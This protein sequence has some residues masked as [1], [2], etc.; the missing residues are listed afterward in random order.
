MSGRKGKYLI[1]IFLL[2][3][4]IVNCEE[5][6]ESYISVNIND[7]L[8]YDFSRVYTNEDSSKL[9]INIEDMLEIIEI[10]TIKID[11]ENKVIKGYVDKQLTESGEEISIKWKLGS[12]ALI[13]EEMLYVEQESIKR[14]F[15][16]KDSRWDE[17]EQTYFLNFDFLTPIE[18]KMRSE[19]WRERNLYT[20][21]NQEIEGGLEV[22]R[23]LFTPGILTFTFDWDDFSESDQT[24]FLEYNSIF[25]RGELNVS[26]EVYE[27]QSLDF[28]RLDYDNIIEDKVISIGDTTIFNAPSIFRGNSNLR[29][30]SINRKNVNYTTNNING[31]EVIEGFAPVR[32]SVELYQNGF[33]I[34]FQSV[35]DNGFFRF[36]DIRSKSLSDSYSVKIYDQ[37]GFF[38]E[39]RSYSSLLN[40]DFMKKGEFDYQGAIGEDDESDKVAGALDLYYGIFSRLTYNPG[41]YYT[42][43]TGYEYSDDDN[44]NENSGKEVMKNS[45]LYRSKKRK[46]P[47]YVKTDLYTDIDSMSNRYEMEYTQKFFFGSQ[48]E[49]YYTKNEAIPEELSGYSDRYK[50]RLSWSWKRWYTSVTYERESAT[51]EE[52]EEN[53][54]GEI[55]YRINN[56]LQVSL[57]EDYDKTN[58]LHL[59][60]LSADYNMNDSINWRASVGKYWGD[61]DGSEYLS[62]SMNKSPNRAESPISFGAGV[63]Y[64]Q[65]DD[66][67]SEWTYYASMKYYFG[68]G[69]TFNANYD[70]E[71]HF[72]A[73]VNYQKAINLSRPF[74]ET[75][76]DAG[77]G[78]WVEGYVFID[79]NANG[80]R[81]EGEEVVE[82]I[83]V[84]SSGRSGSSDTKGYYYIGGITPKHSNE[85][86][87]SYENLRPDLISLNEN[88]KFIIPPTTGNRYDI[89]LVKAS[90]I[91]GFVNV[92]R[93]ANLTDREKEIL[94]NKLK[95]QIIEGDE[96]VKEIPVEGG[97]FYITDGLRPGKYKVR[98]SYLGVKNI[99]F[100]EEELDLVINP[101]KY[102]NFYEGGD[103]K[104]VA[105]DSLNKNRLQTPPNPWDKYDFLP[106]ITSGVMG[107]VELSDDLMIDE[108]KKEMIFTRMR[109]EILSE[110]KVIKEVPVEPGGLYITEGLRPGKYTIIATY[111]GSE[112]FEF[113][114]KLVEINPF[115]YGNFYEGVDLKAVASDKQS[116]SFG[117]V[118]NSNEMQVS[119]YG[120]ENAHF[121]PGLT[122]LEESSKLKMPLSK[123]IKYNTP[124]AIVSG[125]MGRVELSDDL[126]IDERKKEMI[127]ARMKVEIL[128]EGEIIKE[129]PVE[130]GGLYMTEGL[131][132]GRYTVRAYYPDMKNIEFEERFL[133]INPSI[134]GN[135]YEGV[136][137][138]VTSSNHTD[139]SPPLLNGSIGLQSPT[140]IEDNNYFDSSSVSPEYSNELQAPPSKGEKYNT[141]PAIVSGVMGMVKLS[142]DMMMDERKKEMIFARMKVEILHEGRIVKEVPVEPGGFYMTEG[143]MPGRY[144]IRAHYSGIGNLELKERLLEINPAIYGNFYEGIDLKV[145]SFK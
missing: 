102:G 37:R 86:Q 70:N 130:P 139:L 46:Y 9:Y 45:L 127:F 20:G 109:I 12:E 28:V 34:S 97:G 69:G 53:Y 58:D 98:V 31:E 14:I 30:V 21:G 107:R 62:L 87:Y 61:T 36:K 10:E 95:I 44:L 57:E 5:I 79:E 71:D 92:A 94:F 114:E 135:F 24:V 29:G 60:I 63:L 38:I 39:E 143:L 3:S 80:K 27:E 73:G 129:V 134:Y 110:G 119:T 49:L 32:S 133:E 51:D 48:L 8:K 67:D 106:L 75:P 125:V 108:R 99:Q 120:E 17:R 112:N 100:E 85:L 77:D 23:P 76:H 19:R 43:D 145:A 55:T 16:V 15:P 105:Y 89:P 59:T 115:I 13:K 33:L 25:L 64:R 123:E 142:D 65:D 35:D 18:L 22:K 26:G 91:S 90:G 124:P 54:N 131:R 2:I 122:L 118:R 144:A 128:R 11:K 136:D 101:L 74:E 96:V 72:T 78:A 52:T 82:D 116:T 1:G 7:T 41:F 81:D 47:F 40:S 103:L 138:K 66:D 6:Y 137:L 68:E 141:P 4:L 93:E 140:N 104:I 117:P 121:D 83:E 111:S 56:D 126:M 50:G 132:P 113:K 84:Y 42:E 88:N